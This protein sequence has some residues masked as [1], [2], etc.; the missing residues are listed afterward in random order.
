MS[1]DQKSVSAENDRAAS[2]L[3]GNPYILLAFASLF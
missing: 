2:G 1:V 3:A